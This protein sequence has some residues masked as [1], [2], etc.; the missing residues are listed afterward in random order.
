MAFDS[1]IKL[2]MYRSQKEKEVHL[3]T[4]SS[5]RTLMEVMEPI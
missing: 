3:G 5:L 2:I 1:G 4:H